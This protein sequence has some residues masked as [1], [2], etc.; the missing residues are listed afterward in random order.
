MS[1]EVYSSRAMIPPSLLIRDTAIAGALLSG[2]ALFWGTDV[3]LVVLIGAGCALANLLLLVYA[4]RGALSGGRSGVL[5]PMK[6]L[7]AIGMVAF[8]VSIFPPIPVLIG[9]G[10]G[11]LGILLCGIDGIRYLSPTETR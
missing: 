11:P 8:L 6:L 1:F 2:A 10:A 4:A 3:A 5:L 7:L 9:F